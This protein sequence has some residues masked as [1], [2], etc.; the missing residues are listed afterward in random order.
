MLVVCDGGDGGWQWWVAEV[1]RG[2]GDF[3]RKS[4]YFFGTPNLR[5]IPLNL[6][7]YS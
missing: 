2:G 1:V 3:N 6:G 5:G 4:L 7:V